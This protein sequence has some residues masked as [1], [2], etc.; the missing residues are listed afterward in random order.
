MGRSAARHRL[1]GAQDGRPGA[2]V[3]REEVPP[4]QQPARDGSKP[5]PCVPG[6]RRV[7]AT[8]RL[9]RD[10]PGTPADTGDGGDAGRARRL[11]GDGAA[12]AP[13]RHRSVDSRG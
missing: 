2:V 11:S 12:A 6:D 1:H 3:D 8:R 9:H 13:H 5:G 7:P 4:R 10:R